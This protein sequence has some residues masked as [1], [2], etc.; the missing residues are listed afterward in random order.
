MTDAPASVRIQRDDGPVA[1]AVRIG[2]PIPPVAI[3]GLVVVG[4]GA[5]VLATL[6]GVGRLGVAVLALVV[7]LFGA[8]RPR[9]GAGG[10]LSWT[11][12]P[13]LRLLEYATVITLATTA[14]GDAGAAA[15][16]V[17]VFSASYHHYDTVYRFR[18]R[19]DR[20]PPWLVAALGG[21]E[22]RVGLFL[23]AWL[24][25]RATLG[26]LVIGVWC[27]G[28]AVTESIR[29]WRGSRDA[30]PSQPTADQGEIE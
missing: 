20:P 12:P 29:Y 10:R 19:G 15:A 1:S 24:L 2:V 28:L 26:A 22:G 5:V 6:A 17:H 30:E 9:S 8:S 14:D 3:A 16:F 27:G 11:I 13:A 23:L 21:W 18:H 25:G 4:T 7:L